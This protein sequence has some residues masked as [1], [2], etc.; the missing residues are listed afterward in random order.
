[1]V[2]MVLADYVGVE[3]GH[4]DW[5][6]ERMAEHDAIGQ[7]CGQ[8][9][10]EEELCHGLADL[11][12]VW[13]ISLF[14]AGAETFDGLTAGPGNGFIK[15]LAKGVV[16]EQQMHTLGKDLLQSQSPFEQAKG[17]AVLCG[18]LGFMEELVEDQM[19]AGV[20]GQGGKTDDFVEVSLVAVQV[21][22]HNDL[23]GS[24][25]L[26]ELALAQGV[27]QV[28]LTALLV[29]FYNGLV[30]WHKRVLAESRRRE[31]ALSAMAAAGLEPAT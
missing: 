27:G 13:A 3:S 1:M 23:T 29:E 28:G 22:G 9:L 15:D 30:G 17:E 10:R 19:A 11:S 14:Q 7:A 31:A 2:E 8:G 16:T 18:S 4:L 5:R 26:Q 24:G 12:G 20:I 6:G 21:P 25:K